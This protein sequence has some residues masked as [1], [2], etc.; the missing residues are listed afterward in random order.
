[1]AQRS[2]FSQ[3]RGEDA[4]REGGARRIDVTVRRISIIAIGASTLVILAL[5]VFIVFGDVVEIRG[6]ESN[7]IHSIQKILASDQLYSDPSR[8]PFDVVQY[9]PLYYYTV[10]SVASLLAV[11]SNEVH[12]LFEVARFISSIFL[13]L[14][15]VTAYAITRHVGHASRP[16]AIGAVFLLL[17]ATSPWNVLA[18]PDAMATFGSVLMAYC[19]VMAV[20]TTKHPTTFMALAG[21]AG[22]MATLCKQNGLLGLTAVAIY[23]LATRN[24]RS[25]IV[26]GATAGMLLIFGIGAAYAVFGDALMQNVVDGLRNGWSLSSAWERS[27]QPFLTWFGVMLVAFFIAVAHT[28]RRFEAGNQAFLAVYST[29]MLVTSAFASLKIGSAVH[30][31]NDFMFAAVPFLIASVPTMAAFRAVRESIKSGVVLYIAVLLWAIAVD[32]VY[33]YWWLQPTHVVRDRQLI[34]GA[35]RRT[36]A[37]CPDMYILSFDRTV[38][39]LLHDRALMPQPE[40][41]APAHERRLVDYSVFRDLVEQGNVVFV[42]NRGELLPAQVVGAPVSRSRL[43]ATIDGWAVFWPRNASCQ[44]RAL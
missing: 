43:M 15:L 18:R 19:V 26:F 33:R 25:L 28:L 24:I 7:V 36:L 40:L 35:L 42:T 12:A 38:T 14:S 9:M 2:R 22:A 27:A 31:Y 32:Q 44:L 39:L 34:A 17:A 10:A 30:Y 6:V 41:A 8:P 13:L 29:A 11:Q 21:M 5:N 37:A 16:L 1:M 4:S 20:S 23:L 3:L